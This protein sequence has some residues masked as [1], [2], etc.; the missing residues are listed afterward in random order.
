MN[1]AI[2]LIELLRRLSQ[3]INYTP[4]LRNQWVIAELS[5]VRKA[6]G[7]QYFSLIQKDASGQPAATMR[8]TLW[9]GT[10]A[11][12]RAKHGADRLSRLIAGGNEVKLLCSVTFHEK[13]GVALNISDIDPDYRKDT[14][15][16][17]AEILAA[18]A[19]EGIRDNNRQLLMPMPVQKIAVISAAGAAG[20]GDFM[21]QLNGNKFGLTFYTKLFEA[22]MQGAAVSSTVRYAIEAIES[23]PPDLFDCIVIIRGGG[24]TTDLAGFDDLALARAVATCALPVIVGIGHERDRTVLDEIA[25][26]RVKTPTAAAEWLINQAALALSKAIELS[27]EIA[28]NVRNRLTGDMRNIDHLAQLV[29]VLARTRMDNAKARADRLAGMLPLLVT[30][31]VQTASER[32]GRASHAVE[33][34][35]RQAITRASV[36]LQNVS[37]LLTQLLTYRM[38]RERQRLS[39]MEEKIDLLS[40]R[41]ILARGYSITL[42]P[43]GKALRSSLQAAPGTRLLTRLADGEVSSTVNQ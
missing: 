42:G 26:T 29:P 41:T 15:K 18:L 22:T 20:Y 8:A 17:Q 35:G 36:K 11:A 32:L 7:H 19:R 23:T 43:D 6:S 10:F 40:P 28:H 4:A 14:T 31:R 1:D 34:A 12:L 5:D 9:A 30:R 13:Y 33:S 16:V 25:H 2:T 3:T 37:P 38:Q 27:T 39:M 24:A 21:N